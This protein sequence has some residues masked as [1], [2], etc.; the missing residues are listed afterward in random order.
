M[1]REKESILAGRT[2]GWG[3]EGT[4]PPWT[5]AAGQGQPLLSIPAD[6]CG[7]TRHTSEQAGLLEGELGGG[8]HGNSPWTATPGQKQA[9]G[10]PSVGEGNA[11][12]G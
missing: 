10:M 7:N 8:D 3:S 5:P 12:Q 9:W 1:G 4:A 11:V 6:C 2:P